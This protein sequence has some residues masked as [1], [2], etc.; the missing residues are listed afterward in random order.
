[1]K[2]KEKE[3]DKETDP[4]ASRQSLVE[5]FAAL[6]TKATGTNAAF[7][8]ALS[9]VLLWL[10]SGPLFHFSEKWQLIINTVTTVITFLMVFLIQKSQNKDSLAIQLKLNEL[11]AAHEYASNR[12]VSVENMTEDELKIIQKYYHKLGEFAKKEDNLQR[13]HS[14]DESHHL[15]QF[16]EEMELELEEKQKK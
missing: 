7:V 16:K 14:I 12:L 13:P 15:H 2:K 9:A 4:S 11:V 8:I 3:K 1:M 6:V 5:R 10:V